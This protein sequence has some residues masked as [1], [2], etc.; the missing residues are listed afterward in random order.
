[1]QGQEFIMTFSAEFTK[2]QE[3]YEAADNSHGRWTKI[4]GKG[5]NKVTKK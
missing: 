2:W 5:D 3:Y 1:M 4:R